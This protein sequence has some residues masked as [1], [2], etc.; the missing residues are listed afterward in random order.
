MPLNEPDSPPVNEG[1]LNEEL[2]SRLAA[3]VKRA[4]G[5]EAGSRGTRFAHPTRRKEM[6]R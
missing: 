2:R 4:M 1:K 3:V 5:P 6:S